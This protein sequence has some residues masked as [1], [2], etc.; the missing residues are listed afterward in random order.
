MFG[1]SRK[2][3][4]SCGYTQSVDAGFR[5]ERRQ[6][7]YYRFHQSKSKSASAE[8]TSKTKNRVPRQGAGLVHGAGRRNVAILSPF[9][10]WRLSLLRT[11]LL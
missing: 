8:C 11:H 3:E 5:E 4:E 2:K 1:N 7:S 9:G 10:V 6:S